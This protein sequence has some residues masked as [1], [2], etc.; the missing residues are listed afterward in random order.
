[1][2]VCMYLRVGTPTPSRTAFKLGIRSIGP[3]SGFLGLFCTLTNTPGTSSLDDSSTVHSSC[4]QINL[5]SCF[6]EHPHKDPQV[7]LSFIKLE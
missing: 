7:Q 1:M 6:W 5:L 2:Y 4:Q 3:T